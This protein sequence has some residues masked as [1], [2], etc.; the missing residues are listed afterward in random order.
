MGIRGMLRLWFTFHE[1][2][3][4]FEYAAT[5]FG[6]MALKYAVDSLL[7]YQLT[8]GLWSPLDYLTPSWS[9]RSLMLENDPLLAGSLA[10]LLIWSLPFAWIGASMTVRRAKNGGLPAWTG[11]FFFVPLVNYIVMLLLCVLPERRSEAVSDVAE[12]LVPKQL[13]PSTRAFLE[14]AGVGAILMCCLFVASI[15]GLSQY[16]SSLFLGSPFIG[17][18]TV[19]YLYNRQ[20]RAR[21]STAAAVILALLLTGGVMLLLALEGIICLLLA[22]PIALTLAVPAA[23][24]GKRLARLDRTAPAVMIAILSLPLLGMAEAGAGQRPVRRVTTVVEIQAPPDTV[25]RSVI[26]F[27]ELPPP[28]AW[29]FR[30]G[31]AYPTTATIEGIGVGAVRRCTFSTGSFIEPVTTWD[32][33]HRLAFDVTEQPPPMVETSLYPEINAPHLVD[34]L[35][36]HRGEFLLTPLASGGTRLEGSTWYEIR[37]F[38]QLYW[39]FWSDLIIGEIHLRVL[40]HIKRISE[41]A[42]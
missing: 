9:F 28:R 23:Y 2:V 29:P 21:P 13:S 31:I 27:P 30:L 16:G 33:P 6:L 41:A 32:A 24:L 20:P 17:G 10:I 8:G 22:A 18:L 26:T 38:P 12:R 35:I 14:A 1:P 7:V 5:G 36:T 40:D 25:W 42:S 4:R 19:G 3:R 15:Y 39:G 11:I 34:G 37:M